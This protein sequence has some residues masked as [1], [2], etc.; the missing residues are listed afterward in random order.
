MFDV[1]IYANGLLVIISLIISPY[2]WNRHSLEFISV[3]LC[4]NNK[5]K[6]EGKKPSLGE[7]SFLGYFGS[8]S[9]L[10]DNYMKIIGEN[11]EINTEFSI[12]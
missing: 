9:Y 3:Y 6:G 7:I 1:I 4:F 11:M 5:L 2:N 12:D 8:T 10:G